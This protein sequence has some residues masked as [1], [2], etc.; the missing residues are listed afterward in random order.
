MKI[1]KILLVIFLGFFAFILGGCASSPIE[2]TEEDEVII[3]ISMPS[4]AL[5]RWEKD[6]NFMVQ[7]LHELNYKTNIQYAQD[8][9]ETQVDQIENL[10]TRGVDLLVIA[11]IDGEALSPVIERAQKEGIPVIAYDRLIMH[12][13]GI[14]Y[15]VTFDLI[16]VG[17]LQG[18]YI[19]DALNLSE[20]DGPFNIELF[21]GSPDDNNARYFYEGAIEAINPYIE[22]GQL[23]VQSGQTN[24][25]QMAT[26]DWNGA[27]AQRRM[28]DILS[29]SYTNEQLHAVLGPNDAVALGIVS[30][31]KAFGYGTENRPMPIITGQDAEAASIKSIINGEQ[32]MT[33]F[34]DTQALA[35]VTVEMID[36]IF[37]GNDVEVNDTTTYDNG[38]KIVPAN[39]LDPIAVDKSNYQ[40]VIIESGYLSES[41]IN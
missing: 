27:E 23:V 41:D 19:V 32:T 9:V 5:E 3:G 25:N 15:Y 26:K 17:R 36:N 7:K 4:K 31:V 8:G 16:N 33:V 11:P 6:G 12:S 22:S 20:K 14:D 30:S 35:S 28:D 13:D 34:K 38:V 37:N 29:S 18:Q 24:F 21:G 10:I 39:L 2:S 1:K 40:E